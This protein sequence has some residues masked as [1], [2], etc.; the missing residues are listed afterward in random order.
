M[1]DNLTYSKKFSPNILVGISKTF[2]EHFMGYVVK[3][4]YDPMSSK[5]SDGHIRLSVG[6]DIKCY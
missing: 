5:L 6:S 1:A 4:I 3:S 2:V